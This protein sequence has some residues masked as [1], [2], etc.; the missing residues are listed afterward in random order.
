MRKSRKYKH[1]EIVLRDSGR[2]WY[3]LA[4]ENTSAYAGRDAWRSQYLPRYLGSTSRGLGEG[5]TE[6]VKQIWASVTVRTRKLN[7]VRILRIEVEPLH[8]LV[9]RQ[10]EWPTW[11]SKGRSGEERRGSCRKE[12]EDDYDDD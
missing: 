6:S 8:K 11:S 9:A 5:K 7:N 3:Y 4:W 2:F 10:I 1:I 12:E